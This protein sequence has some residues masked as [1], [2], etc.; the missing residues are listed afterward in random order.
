MFSLNLGQIQFDPSHTIDQHRPQGYSNEMPHATNV[1]YYFEPTRVNATDEEALELQ[2]SPRGNHSNS[3]S[4][5]E[6]PEFLEIHDPKHR[7]PRESSGEWRRLIFNED[8]HQ[9]Y[10][11]GRRFRTLLPTVLL[12]VFADHQLWLIIPKLRQDRQHGHK[13]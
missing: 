6:V 2:I 3:Q 8:V 12:Y 9:S 7:H 11:N 10:L 1:T 5:A 4:E 13:S